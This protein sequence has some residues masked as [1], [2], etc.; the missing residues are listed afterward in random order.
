MT[1]LGLFG[2]VMDM[3]IILSLVLEE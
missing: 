1:T 3:T 2:M